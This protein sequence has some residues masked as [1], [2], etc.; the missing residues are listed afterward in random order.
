[1]KEIKRFK[2]VTV[3]DHQNNLVTID[4]SANAAGGRRVKGVSR[5]FKVLLEHVGTMAI[6]FMPRGQ[7][8]LDGLV[9][10]LV[11]SYRFDL[12]YV[13]VSSNCLIMFN[14]FYRFLPMTCH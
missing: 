14:D 2:R 4:L 6:F 11:G 13:N 8:W 10:K 3:K 12:A 1:M 9:S 7:D 5:C